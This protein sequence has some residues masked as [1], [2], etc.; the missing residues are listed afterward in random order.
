[1]E[2][3]VRDWM[4]IIGAGLIL[5]VL[6]DAGRRV[7]AERR[8]EIRLN[9]KIRRGDV[10]DTEDDFDLLSELPNGGARIVRAADLGSEPAAAE[11][12]DAEPADSET[13]EET[14]SAAPAWA[15]GRPEPDITPPTAGAAPGAD[16]S[17]DSEDGLMS[18][19][20]TR[21][22]TPENLDWLD[23]LDGDEPEQTAEEGKLPRSIDPHVFVLNVVAHGES[24]F[25]GKDI[26]KI[27]L[28]CDLR[29]GDM[30]FF[31]RHEQAAGR[32]PIQFSVANMMKPGVFD[33]DHMDELSTR[34]LMF[35]V[36][37]PGPEDM[38]K[39][40]DYMY[41]TAKAVAKNLHG[42]VLD[43]TRSVVTQ[44]SLEHMRQQIRE[45]ERRILVESER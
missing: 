34:G 21:D 10:D 18:G 39:A 40:F 11:D 4:V 45:L 20:S 30:D 14:E 23:Q 9:T 35:F 44:Q 6:V 32:G 31:H 41:E 25:A 8:S 7:Y 12:S 2:L 5:A 22:E 42:D 29:F 13:R 38:L 19:M 3:T 27:L 17:D 28:A 24:G 36:T 43:E 26:L 1:M 16:E 33:I 37:L 15:D